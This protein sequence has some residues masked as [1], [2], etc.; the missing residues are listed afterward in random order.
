[1]RL[2][3]KK[4][5]RRVA[6]LAVPASIAAVAAATGPVQTPAVAPAVRVVSFGG[7]S[8][9]PLLVA[10]AQGIFARHGVG[11]VTEFTPNSTVL[12]QGLADGTYE[13]A[14]AA[15]D[16]AV[17]MAETAGVDVVV[18]MG[19]DDSMN[20]LFVQPGIE[21]AAALKG[22]TLAVDA[23][24]TAYALQ[25][26]KILRLNGLENGRDYTLEVVGGTPQ[27]LQAMLKNSQLTASM[28]NPP[29][30]IQAARAGLRSLGSASD[31]IGAYQGMSGFV[32]RSWAQENRE[33]LVRYLAAYVEA[34][35]WF[36]AP[37]NKTAALDVL[38]ARLKLEPEVAAATYA[39][40]VRSPGG[41]F[42][43]AEIDVAGFA[44]VLKLRAEIEGQW[45][46][47]PPPPEKYIDRSFLDAAIASLGR[48][49]GR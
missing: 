26:R 45:H 12:R 19:I 24:N 9:V 33:T 20:E 8:T 3:V 46:G 34:L 38:T 23:P 39:L 17:A 18:V 31:L 30:S 41:L 36:L 2:V 29:F 42:P 4:V 1:M 27:R 25:G 16:N 35:R 32:R 22:R 47:M 13:I 40:A 10:E 49:R 7:V 14:H 6:V 11:V 28:L 37:G 5:V 43:D 15:A 44:N 48:G 21:S